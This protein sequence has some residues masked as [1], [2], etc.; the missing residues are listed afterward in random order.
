MPVL[1]RVKPELEVRSQINLFELVR[2]QPTTTIFMELECCKHRDWVFVFGSNLAGRHGKGAALHAKQFHGA[3]YGRNELNG[4]AG[5][6]SYGIP[7]KDAKLKT[8]SLWRIRPYIDNFISCAKV[9]SGTGFYVTRIGCGLAGY[10]DSDIA[11][12]FKNAP[13]NCI[14]PRGWGR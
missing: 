14:L 2:F 9:L 13:E 6:W 3:R 10:K 7:T 12:M 11:P 1:W 5:A 8:L 4:Q